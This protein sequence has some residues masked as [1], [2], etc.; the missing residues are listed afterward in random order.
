VDPVTN[1]KIVPHVIEPAVGINRLLLM[2]LV[3]AYNE[4]ENRTVLK[5]HPK[6]APY[7]AAVFPLLANKPELVEKARG[8][9]DKLKSEFNISWDDRGNIGK[10]YLSQD[11]AGTPYCITVDFQTLE[12]DTV[13]VRDRDNATQERIE[14]SKL[15]DFIKEKIS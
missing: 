3:D 15:L 8:I 14:I 5:L 1:Q 13:T 12:D 9:Y 2:V 4:E 10:R 11:E 6:L 7:K